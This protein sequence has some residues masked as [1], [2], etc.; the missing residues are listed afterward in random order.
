MQVQEELPELTPEEAAELERALDAIF[1]DGAEG[2][3]EFDEQGN[4]IFIEDDANDKD[5]GE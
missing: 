3:L 2:T 4:L 1:A 5:D